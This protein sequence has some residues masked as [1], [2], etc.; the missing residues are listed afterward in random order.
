MQ[1]RV[2]LHERDE[3]KNWRKEL[4]DRIRAE[5]EQAWETRTS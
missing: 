1:G 4:D 3:V 5:F 2:P